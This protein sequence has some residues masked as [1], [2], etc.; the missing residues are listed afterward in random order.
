MEEVTKTAVVLDIGSSSTKVGLKGD[1]D[2]RACIPTV[3]EKVIPSIIPLPG[4]KP[5]IWPVEKGRVLDFDGWQKVASAALEELKISTNEKPMVLVETDL[6]FEHQREKLTEILFETFQIPSLCL[7][8]QAP[9][10][11]L[12]SGRYTGVCLY[13]GESSYAVACYGGSTIPHTLTMGRSGGAEVTELGR[14]LMAEKEI[15]VA[16]VKRALDREVC[17]DVKENC[18]RLFKDENDNTKEYEVTKKHEK[19]SLSLSRFAKVSRWKKNNFG[20]R[21]HGSAIAKIASS[22]HESRA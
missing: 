9:L 8:K 3:Y 14:Q 1:V 11:V 21:M 13:S 5:L 10:S 12:A 7:A 17:R 19:D 2:P 16:D 22:S 6:H 4:N 18:F 15:F 20:S